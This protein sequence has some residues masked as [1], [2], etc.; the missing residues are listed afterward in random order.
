MFEVD[1]NR[2][3]IFLLVCIW[4]AIAATFPA[5]PIDETRYLTVAWEMRHNHQWILPTLNG[6]PYSHKPPLLFWLINLVWAVTGPRVWAARIVSLATAIAVFIL[7]GKL[8]AKLFPDRPRVASIARLLTLASPFFMIY[9]GMIMFDFLLYAAVLLSLIC[10]WQAGHEKA[11]RPW[12]L[13]GLAMGFGVLAKGPVILV[14]VMGPA[15]LAPFLWLPATSGYSKTGWYARLIGAI[16]IATM[17]G[18]AW[19]GPAALIGGPQF[20]HMIFWGQSAGRMVESFAHRRPFWFY[21]PFV[22][23]F[24][25]PWLCTQP[26]WRAL[27]DFRIATTEPQVRFLLCWIGPAFVAFSLI[28]GKQLHYIVPL[29]SGLAIVMATC[30]ERVLKT[31]GERQTF[32]YALIV[33]GIAFIGLAAA[34][35][36]PFI[37]HSHSNEVLSHGVIHF[38]S[39]V[40]ILGLFAASAILWMLRKRFESQLLAMILSGGLLLTL[41]TIEGRLH[42]YSYFDLSPIATAMQPYRGH[43][44]AYVGKYAGE[45][46]FVAKLDK[47]VADIDADA[48]PQ[49]FAHY[50]DGI[51]VVRHE[52]YEL[53]PQYKTLFSMNYK[54][55]QRFSLL[56]PEDK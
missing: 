12:I 8:A 7:T 43:P 1:Y 10:L 26:F 33:Y 46:G 2:V 21:L 24:I 50:P 9:G 11:M 49:W 20:A 25:L 32:P 22:P 36:L 55:D 51:A 48:L 47:P 44:V 3:G 53:W 42:A 52:D 38:N 29:L 34:P 18:F 35:F 17:V 56:V 30:I 28:S 15:L 39:V 5:F 41:T 54:G 31:T 19:A 23:V 37:R 6:A 40:F 14:H 27:R 4:L 13:F 16:L 45:I